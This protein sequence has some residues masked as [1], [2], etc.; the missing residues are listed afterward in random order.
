MSALDMLEL[1]EEVAG[2]NWV[3]CGVDSFPVASANTGATEAT[4]IGV[5]V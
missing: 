5:K 1:L 2:L 4:S 3:T